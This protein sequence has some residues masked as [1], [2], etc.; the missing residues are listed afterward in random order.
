MGINGSQTHDIRDKVLL[1]FPLGKPVENK[2]MSFFD[3]FLDLEPE[4]CTLCGRTY[5]SKRAFANHCNRCAKQFAHIQRLRAEKA[6]EEMKELTESR[7]FRYK[8]RLSELCNIHQE[9]LTQ[10]LKTVMCLES[11]RAE[12]NDLIDVLDDALATD[13]IT[14]SRN[15]QTP[16]Q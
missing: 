14:Q 5:E 16:S 15:P 11:Q 10:I 13:D 4:Q 6:V 1:N 3:I 8:Q 9:E 2:C 7:V 12:L